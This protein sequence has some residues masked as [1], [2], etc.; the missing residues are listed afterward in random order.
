VENYFRVI[1]GESGEKV[2]ITPI[3]KDLSGVI[4]LEEDEDI[5]DDYAQYL[6]EKYRL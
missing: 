4:K 6:I 2:E 3:V 1:T 5:K